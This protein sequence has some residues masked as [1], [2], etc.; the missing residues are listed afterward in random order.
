M[1]IEKQLKDMINKHMARYFT[2]K[3]NF[4]SPLAHEK[5]FITILCTTSANTSGH[6][7]VVSATA[8]SLSDDASTN[9]RR[10][11]GKAG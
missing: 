1:T 7:L 8:K 6:R 3:L 4:Y 5:K 11:A 9:T 2:L 10:L